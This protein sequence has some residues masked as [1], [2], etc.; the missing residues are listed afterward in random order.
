[1][2]GIFAVIR[3]QHLVSEEEVWCG[4][5]EI[6]HRGPD[7]GAVEVVG[8]VGLGFRRLAILDTSSSGHQPMFSVERDRVII[9]NGEI[10]NFV[11]IKE[12]LLSKGLLFFTNSDTEV[13][14]AAYQVWGKEMFAKFNGMFAIVLYDIHRKE[15]VIG[16]DRF[17]KKPLFVYCS[18]D[19]VAFASE[20]KSL[21]GVE[22]FVPVLNKVAIATYVRLGII[23]NK[24]TIYDGIFKAEPGC[25]MVFNVNDWK[26]SDVVSYWELPNYEIETSRSEDQWV[27]EIHDLLWDATR[28]RL[29]SDVPIGVFLSGG[30]DSGL[31]AAAAS[32]F[33]PDIQSLTIG[34]PEWSR[35]EWPLAKEMAQYLNIQAIHAS[36][37]GSAIESL[38]MLMAHFDEPFA[39][40]SALPTSLVCSEARKNMTVVLSGDG[41][42][43]IFAGYPH[44]LRAMDSKRFYKLPNWLRQCIGNAAY[45]MPNDSPY[46]RALNRLKNDNTHWGM[47]DIF[48]PFE[49]WIRDLIHPD[50]YPSIKQFDSVFESLDTTKI[51]SDHVWN[52]QVKDIQFYMRDDIL[53]KVDRM[54]MLNSLEVRSP[55]LD[56]RLLDLSARIPSELKVK[57]N[58][59]K[60]LLRRLAK[61]ILPDSVTEAPKTGFGIPV[62]Q[63]I[64]TSPKQA[65]YIED[66][67]LLE[68]WQILRTGGGVKLWELAKTNSALVG[69]LF[70][71]L[72]L[73]WWLKRRQG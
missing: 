38:E 19:T 24:L 5:N 33:K 42:D 47:G 3:R 49:D 6:V 20:L 16:R 28:I 60:Y 59:N 55:F 9:F 64:F 41:G 65:S 17:G 72:S 11:E 71:M 48:Y 14:L 32:Q 8:N 31:V 30:I 58:T 62:A 35:D 69:A 25:W 51:S 36:I 50:L 26:M 27:D 2:C 67:Q 29:R 43:E 45:L 53:V 40:S 61:R 57:N 21:D 37:D 23:P 70:R 12:E 22:G 39:D 63:W 46:R 56:Y 54:S 66:L 52:A 68:S 1:M 13:I 10:Y 15:I 34:I 4:V 18:K 73:A 7:H 44:Y